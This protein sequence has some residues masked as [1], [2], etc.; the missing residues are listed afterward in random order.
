MFVSAIVSSSPPLVRC[1]CIP[2]RSHTGP[3]LCTEDR[4]TLPTSSFCSSPGAA[5]FPLLTAIFAACSSLNVIHMVAL[6]DSQP[7]NAPLMCSVTGVRLGLYRLNQT[8]PF[9]FL[10]GFPF[11]THF[12]RL[13]RSSQRPAF[14]I[15]RSDAHRS[16]GMIASWSA[17]PSFVKKYSTRGGISENASRS[18]R[19][20]SCSS[21][22]VSDSVPGLTP[23]S[24]AIRSLNLSRPFV[25]SLLMMRSAHFLDIVVRIPPNAHTHNVSL[26]SH[27]ATTLLHS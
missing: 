10:Q 3:V 22:S 20:S 1:C 19:C 5:P 6:S 2:L 11:G 25:P 27:I 13:H 21:F 9:D 7:L 12:R 26:F 8:E 18:T 4:G 16:K 15:S 14:W 24:S 17:V 23:S